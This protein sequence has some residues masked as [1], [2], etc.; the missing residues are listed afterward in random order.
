MTVT[1]NIEY[2]LGEKFD[3]AWC[4]TEDKNVINKNVM[5]LK[6]S[7]GTFLDNIGI[8]KDFLKAYKNTNKRKSIN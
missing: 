5:F 8:C 1:E 4:C 7:K 2:S 3:L 6:D